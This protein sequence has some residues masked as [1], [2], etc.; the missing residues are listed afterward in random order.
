MHSRLG[1]TCPLSEKERIVLHIGFQDEIPRYR[2]QFRHRQE[3]GQGFK[4]HGLQLDWQM[5]RAWY[6]CQRSK[7]SGNAERSTQYL[8]RSLLGG[9]FQ[10]TST[11]SFSHPLFLDFA[12]RAIAFSHSHWGAGIWARRIRRFAEPLGWEHGV[13]GWL[14]A[15]PEGGR[16]WALGHQIYFQIIIAARQLV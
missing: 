6:S 10:L 9:V 15:I 4:P 8:R 12:R 2:S 3:R 11:P 7:Y 14:L 13:C 16:H 5:A 1:P